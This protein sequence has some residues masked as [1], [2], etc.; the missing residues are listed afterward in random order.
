[1][2]G[3]FPALM[4]ASVLTLTSASAVPVVWAL[5][6]N[7]SVYIVDAASNAELPFIPSPVQSDSL[8]VDPAG[9]L[10][11]ADA[12]GTV[13]SVQGAIPLGA[14]GFTQIAD[15][16]YAPGGL[17]GFSNAADTLFFFDLSSASVTYSLGIT[18]GLGGY[19]I[20]GVAW[21]PSTGDIYLSGNT[22]YNLDALFL[23]DLNTASAALVG[24]LLH[25][26]A[27]SYVSDIEFAGGGTLLAMTWYHRDFYAVNPAT[28]ATT[29]LS[30]GP[31]RDVTGL[32]AITSVPEAGTGAA[33][34]AVLFAAWVSQGRRVRVSR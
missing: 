34:A 16:C 4:I 15:L 1:M 12:A 14:T 6:F 32:A 19:D 29:L 28:A 27:L 22:G 13:Y 31:H 23:L 3:K 7:Q 5:G 17:W 24:S 10:Y 8:A 18:S 9:V 20:T 11:V 33:A 2:H 26:D 21:Q 30:A 25:S